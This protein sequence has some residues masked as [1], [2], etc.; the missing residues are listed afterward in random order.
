[1][2]RSFAVLISII[3]CFVSGCSSQKYAS[4]VSWDEREYQDVE[5]DNKERYLEHTTIDD[6]LLEDAMQRACDKLRGNI[7]DFKNGFPNV[8]TE[9]GSYEVSERFNWTSGML[10]GCY[11]LAYQ[12]TGDEVFKNAAEHMI[13]IFAEH[14]KTGEWLNDHDTGFIYSPSCVAGYKITGDESMK[15][16]AL[17]AAEILYNHYDS[18]NKFI[19]RSGKRSDN[20]YDMYR[21]LVD[22]MMNIPLFFFAY[23]ETGDEKYLNASVDHYHTT[24]AY[25]I[26]DDG[27][28]YHHYQFDPESGNPVKGLTWQGYSDESC[29]SRGHSWLLYGF[30]IAYSYTQ[31]AEILPLYKNISNYYLNRLPS[32]NIPY[33]DLVFTESSDEPRD[34]SAAAIS[35]C[36]FLEM[37]NHIEDE[38]QKEIL[39]NA[40]D[41]HMLSLIKNCENRYEGDGLL[42]HVAYAVPQELGIDTSTIFADYF[43]MEALMR[44]LEPDFIRYW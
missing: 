23:E 43:Y 44:Y 16:A 9:N 5:L 10:T 13:E 25:L 1:M 30:P 15:T 19:I 26:R 36:G 32:D 18:E 29:W 8:A 7:G 34:S 3:I 14:A 40:A 22:S 2:K 37:I 27:S 20:N 24:M 31:N 6:V 28:S 4:K 17:D 11:W 33:W 21:A 12:Y 38:E 35:I 41:A 42:N 39:K